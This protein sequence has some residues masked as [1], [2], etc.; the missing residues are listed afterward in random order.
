MEISVKQLISNLAAREESLVLES[1]V[2]L[3]KKG[4]AE[5][6]GALLECYFVSDSAA[7]KNEIIMLFNDVKDN[8]VAGVW[9]AGLEKYI[10]RPGFSELLSCCWMARV[11]FGNEL[12]RFARMFV[13]GNLMTAIEAITVIEQNMGSASEQTIETMLAYLENECE[14]MIP[15]TQK[16]Y[17]Q[18]TNELKN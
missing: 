4:N 3:R 5:S 12:M 10:D 18:W 13:K 15:D 11:D 1:I 17:K 8:R 2:A 7:I 16:I 14:A 6:V 9:A